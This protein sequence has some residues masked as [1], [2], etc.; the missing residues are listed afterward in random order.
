MNLQVMTPPE[1]VMPPIRTSATDTPSAVIDRHLDNV[2]SAYQ[3]ACHSILA[4]GMALFEAR[5][6]C[7][8]EEWRELLN[9]PRMPICERVAQRFIAI[10]T[11]PGISND[12]ASRCLPADYSTLAEIARLDPDEYR[13]AM[14]EGLLQ[15]DLSCRD[16]KRVVQQ[17][18]K[19]GDAVHSEPLNETNTHFS[20]GAGDDEAGS[21]DD[22]PRAEDAAEEAKAAE[23]FM[24]SFG[25]F[26]GCPVETL[27]CLVAPLFDVRV[28]VMQREHELQGQA[29]KDLIAA[30]SVVLYLL[31][32][33]FGYSYTEAT[34][35]YGLDSSVMTSVSA[36]IEGFRDSE[37]W[38][39]LLDG[40]SQAAEALVGD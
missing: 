16:A 28:K 17:V 24:S 35:P 37:K 15:P 29:R 11:H 39:D 36:R 18:R 33:T 30:R 9:S 27:E 10:A 13:A 34:A 19:R 12:I 23:V 7:S 8:P 21:E 14:D 22:D 40:L 20:D 3:T 32:T 26:G 31:S 6:E 25:S 5:Q 1:A 38:S 4:T 2:R